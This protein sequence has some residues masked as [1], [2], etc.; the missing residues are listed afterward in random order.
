MKIHFDKVVSFPNHSL[1]HKRIKLLLS[2]LPSELKAQFNEIHVGNQLAEK[3]KFD[4]PAVLM[5]AARKLKVLDR[6]VNEFQLVEEIL[7][8]LVQAA[9]ELDGEQHHVLKAHADHHLDL[10]QVKQ[11]H[12]I[13]EPYLQ[14][15]ALKRISAA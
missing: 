12:S 14:A 11:I 5:P 3:S 4:R 10:K 9:A 6:G 7:V 13:I 8:E 1:S 2:V 15:Y